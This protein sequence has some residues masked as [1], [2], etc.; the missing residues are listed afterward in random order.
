[1]IT[2]NAFWSS[3]NVTIVNAALPVTFNKSG[4]A[5]GGQAGFNWQVLAFVFSVEADIMS[6]TG[7]CHPHPDRFLARPQTT[8]H[9]D[10]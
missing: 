4:F 6:L 9:A 2:S 1:V 3:N 5:G 8:R 7:N 10:R